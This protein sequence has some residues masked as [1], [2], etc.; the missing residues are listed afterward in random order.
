MRHPVAAA[1]GEVA[2]AQERGTPGKT[3]ARLK[4]QVIRW[5]HVSRVAALPAKGER[6]C[7]NIA[8]HRAILKGHGGGEREALDHVE[9]EDTLAIVFFGPGHLDVVSYTE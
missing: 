5:S 7:L 8:Q 4:V 3:E 1:K 9:P 6:R 2:I